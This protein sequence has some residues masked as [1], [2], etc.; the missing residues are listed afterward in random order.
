MREPQPLQLGERVALVA[1]SSPVMSETALTGAIDFVTQ[2]GY[3]PVL[4]QHVSAHQGHLAGSDAQRAADINHAFADPTIKGVFAIRGGNGAGRILDLIDYELIRANPKFFAGY[5]DITALHLALNQRS[6]LVTYH[7]PTLGEESFTQS[8]PYTL[9]QLTRLIQNPKQTGRIDLPPSKP[10]HTLVAGVATAQ[11]VGG[12]LSCMSALMGTPYEVDT[13][14]KLLFIEEVGS[15][16][17]RIDRMLHGLRLAGK[18]EQAA[19]VIFGDF[20]NCVPDDANY[21]LSMDDIF[22]GLGITTPAVTNLA[23]GHELVSTSLPLGR[24]YTLDADL[25]T[26]TLL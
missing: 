24:T 9:A 4:G 22:S 10:L 21:S 14:G 17:P 7:T 13:R 3:M 16:P 23:C 1:P 15:K 6:Q 20:T 12:N 2:L 11:L 25:G 19:G 18:F 5:S 26:L 8:D